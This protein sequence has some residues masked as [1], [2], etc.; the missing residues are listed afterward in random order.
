MWYVEGG[1]MCGGGVVCGG[2][3]WYVEGVCGV[4]REGVVCGEGVWSIGGGC[5]EC[6]GRVCGVRRGVVLADSLQLSCH[7]MLLPT[8]EGFAMKLYVG[9]VTC[10]FAFQ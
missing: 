1:V 8:I 3:V 10:F 7:S 6:G 2:G 9:I 4:R 5:V